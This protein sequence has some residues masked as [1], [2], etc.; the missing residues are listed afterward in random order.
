MG[1][2]NPPF[3]EYNSKPPVF[4]LR[5]FAVAG[6]RRLPPVHYRRF[7]PRLALVLRLL[8]PLL[9]LLVLRLALLRLLPL[10]RLL[11]RLLYPLCPHMVTPPF[12]LVR[13]ISCPTGSC[14]P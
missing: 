12:G 13:W 4:R 2:R 10:L 1:G 14:W 9:R 3:F 6:F 5:V 8:L 11:L 7:P